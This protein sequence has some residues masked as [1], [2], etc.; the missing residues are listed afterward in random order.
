MMY[1]W[2]IL[3]HVENRAEPRENSIMKLSIFRNH[4]VRVLNIGL[5]WKLEFDITVYRIPA[6]DKQ[7]LNVFHITRN[8]NGGNDNIL[9]LSV[10]RKGSHGEF[11]FQYWKK[12]KTMLFSLGTTYHIIIE[13]YKARRG[14]RY[15]YAI[16]VDDDDLVN[17]VLIKT[18]KTR[19]H[20]KLYSSNPWEKTMTPKIGAVKNF[21]ITMEKT[22]Q[23]CKNIIIDI[24]ASYLS[25]KH[26]KLQKSLIGQYSYKGTRN[27]RGYWTK[28][29]GTAAIWYYKDYKEWMSGDINYL[30]TKWHGM[31]AMQTS[32]SCPTQNVKRWNFWNGI[33]WRSGKSHIHLYCRENFEKGMNYV[34]CRY[35]I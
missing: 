17:E 9:K 28:K 6:I 11:S 15:Q 23:C 3:Q 34:L 35:Y 14:K 33:K 2:H 21:V 7:L 31:S 5:T 4:L 22:T 16:T 18:P 13:Q 10:Y 1:F 27:G 30:G 25:S 26:A 20:A 19:N 29:D 8:G 32:V 12:T 24:D